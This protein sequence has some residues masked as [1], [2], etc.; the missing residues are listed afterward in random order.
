M[1]SALQRYLDDV[2][3]SPDDRAV[4]K[5]LDSIRGEKIAKLGLFQCI[6]WCGVSSLVPCVLK[7]ILIVCGLVLLW[8]F[9]SG[10]CRLL[11]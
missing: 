4:D 11:S 7:T 8:I 2:D 6:P 5:L 1:V 10:R 9:C 3:T